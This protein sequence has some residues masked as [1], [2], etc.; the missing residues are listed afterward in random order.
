VIEEED[1]RPKRV[2]DL[3]E[4]LQQMK[5][6]EEGLNTIHKIYKNI[7]IDILQ[8]KNVPENIK[9]EMWKHEVTL[10]TDIVN[11][12]GLFGLEATV[13][14]VSKAIKAAILKA[15]EEAE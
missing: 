7:W 12:Q 2:S 14:E 1:E 15:L 13:R 9:Y 4:F 10:L 11:K 5:I 8:D 6:L 3:A